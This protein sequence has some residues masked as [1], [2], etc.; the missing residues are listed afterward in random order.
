MKTTQLKFTGTGAEYKTPAMRLFQ[1]SLENN[2]LFSN[3]EGNIPPL[4]EADDLGDL[5]G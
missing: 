1:S 3:T 4:Q 2:F 5:W